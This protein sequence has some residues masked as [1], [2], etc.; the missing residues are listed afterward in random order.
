M[1]FDVVRASG[2]SRRYNAQGL[3]AIT[4]VAHAYWGWGDLVVIATAFTGLTA[5]YI[6]C[7]QGASRIIFSMA[8]QRLLPR[9]FARLEGDKRVPRMAVLF[10]VLTCATVGLLSLAV[11]RNGLDSFVWWSNAMVF[12]A[13]LTFTGVN[14]ANFLYFR[15]ILPQQFRVV[16]NLLVPAAGVA[17]NLYLIYAAFFSALWSASFRMGRSVVLVCLVLFA[18]ELLTAIWMRLYRRDL[19]AAPIGAEPDRM[20][21]E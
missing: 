1:G 16:R 6:G 20:A 3:T 12:F 9:V 5:I 15:R 11:L 7:V 19:L 21:A 8:R 4:P 17:V 10:V 14:A 2:R 18:L 13:A